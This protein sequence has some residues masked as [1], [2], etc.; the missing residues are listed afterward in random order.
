MTSAYHLKRAC[1]AFERVGLKVIP[2][3]S[4]L[5]KPENEKIGWYSFLPSAGSLLG[6][7]RA[8]HEYLGMWALRAGFK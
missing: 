8:L 6:V 2:F 5:A 4:F 7:S 3:P 1:L